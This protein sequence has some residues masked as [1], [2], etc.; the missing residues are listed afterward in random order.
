MHFRSVV[1]IRKHRSPPS[2]STP[3]QGATTPKHRSPLTSPPLC[4]LVTETRGELGWETNGTCYVLDGSLECCKPKRLVFKNLLQR[5]WSIYTHICIAVHSLRRLSAL[6]YSLV[7]KYSTSR[8]RNVQSDADIH[9]HV[10]Q[11]DFEDL[12]CSVNRATSCV[13]EADVSAAYRSQLVVMMVTHRRQSPQRTRACPFR[14]IFAIYAIYRYR[15]SRSA[16][17][18]SKLDKYQ[19]CIDNTTIRP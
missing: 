7:I 2:Q 3:L 14:S 6:V 13:E 17:C 5:A 1:C 4:F 9:V 18:F 12:H 8:W 15:I 19:A 11:Y 10:Y 16:T